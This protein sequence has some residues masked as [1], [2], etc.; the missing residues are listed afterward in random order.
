MELAK[1]D[2]RKMT[3]T[4]TLQVGSTPHAMVFDHHGRH[5]FVC[6][7]N[8][9]IFNF[10]GTGFKS[11]EM[12]LVGKIDLIENKEDHESGIDFDLRYRIIQ[13]SASLTNLC[14]GSTIKTR[15]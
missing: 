12:K 6:E 13:D 5:L 14:T 1:L 3:W 8:I 9:S 11:K 7:G 10:K 15:L 2:L 4:G